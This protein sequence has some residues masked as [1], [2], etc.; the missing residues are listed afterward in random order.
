VVDE[1]LQNN[2]YVISGG[3]GTGKTTLI[4]L[5]Q[6]RGYATVPEMA[7]HYIDEQLALGKSFNEVENHQVA[8]Q[9][10]VLERQLAAEKLLP[11]DRV[12]FFDRGIPDTLAYY[13]YHKLPEDEL[14]TKA[15]AACSYKKVFLLDPLPIVSDYARKETERQ[16]HDLCKRIREVYASLP[17]PTVRVPVMSPNERVEFVLSNV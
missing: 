6:L 8:F 9:H 7:R 1:R 3:P 5:L 10:A 13:Q 11:F 14:I 17:F 15:V 4:T 16:Q 12:T 2:W